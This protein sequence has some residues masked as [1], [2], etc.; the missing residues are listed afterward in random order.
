MSSISTRLEGLRPS[1]LDIQ[2]LTT[3]TRTNVRRRYANN[4]FGAAKGPRF[5]VVL[6]HC[7]RST[8]YHVWSF[9]TAKEARHNVC[10]LSFGTTIYHVCA[11]SIGN[12]KEAL[13]NYIADFLLLFPAKAM[14]FLSLPSLFQPLP[15]PPL[16]RGSGGIIT[17]GHFLTLQIP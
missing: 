1:A 12:A 10:A 16:K 2:R 11:W 17:P 3:T 4:G 5:F 13:H 6:W 8:V 7:Q 15:I 14:D 9:G